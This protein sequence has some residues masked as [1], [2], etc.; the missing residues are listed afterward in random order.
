MFGG[1]S[2]TVLILI[3]LPALIQGIDFPRQPVIVSKVFGFPGKLIFDSFIKQDLP[4]GYQKLSAKD[5]LDALWEQITKDETSSP[6]TPMPKMVK[7][8]FRNMNDVF[9][10]ESDERPWRGFKPIHSTGYHAKAKFEAAPGTPYTGLFKG[11]KH[12]LVR[13]APGSE[14]KTSLLS[15][16][17]AKFLVDGESSRNY[18]SFRKWSTLRP[19]DY[20]NEE[21]S[22][23][24]HWF[25]GDQSN[26]PAPIPKPMPYLILVPKFG[27]ASREPNH[28]GLKDIG[29]IDAKGNKVENPKTPF[30]VIMRPNKNMIHVTLENLHTVPSGTKLYDVYAKESTHESPE[31]WIGS[32][33]STSRMTTSW[34]GDR[35]LFFQHIR[36]DDDLKKVFKLKCPYMPAQQQYDEYMADRKKK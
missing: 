36:R 35:K 14:P 23:W 32:V 31:K 22:D 34:W 2:K 24:Q 21:G 26:C 5:K 15:G 7:L 12:M 4:K 6:Y 30:E 1:I 33:T 19:Q 11:C 28:L 25:D 17:S 27:T 3:T 18:L 20:P 9:D 8:F 29:D 13:L 16:I 10:H